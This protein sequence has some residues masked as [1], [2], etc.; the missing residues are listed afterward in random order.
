MHYQSN[1]VD[2]IL[3][4]ND[5]E[6]VVE[7]E[8]QNDKLLASRDIITR[9]TNKSNESTSKEHIGDGNEQH[10]TTISPP[11]DTIEETNLT[12]TQ[13]ETIY[14]TNSITGKLN[15]LDLTASICIRSGF[16]IASKNMQRV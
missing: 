10:D 11:E 4:Q 1:G 8:V 13:N 5:I 2:I 7:N 14:I 15:Q 12:N 16:K 3:S 9:E 6:I